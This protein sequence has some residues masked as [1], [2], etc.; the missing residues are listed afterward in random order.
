MLD[1]R[2][3]LG[4]GP[5]WHPDRAALSWVEIYEGRVNWLGLDGSAGESVEVGRRVG[6]AVPAAGGALALATDEG[7]AH[8]GPDGEYVFLAAVDEDCDDWFMNDGRCD[9][10]GRFWAGTVGV[11]ERGLAAERAG[12]LYCLETDGQVRRV[13]DG[14]S[15]SNGL[16]W[17]PDG[18]TFYY[19]DSLAG[20]IDAF[21]FDLSS[22][23]LSGRRRVVELGFPA[24]VGFVDGICVDAD[25]GLWAA[26]WG[27]GEVRRYTPDGELD[28][29]IRLPVSQPTSCVFAGDALDV[30]VITSA[31]RG[32]SGDELERQPH[33]GSVFRCRP[34]P[35]GLPP[36]PCRSVTS[37]EI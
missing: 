35:T 36:N 2:A 13:L 37:L 24:E 30:L 5:I 21:E 16:D 15:L 14:V 25:G 7:F 8:I 32:L 3:D 4:E 31:R 11:N 22:G 23:A 28:A 34:G 6:A 17:S 9:A 12:S 27:L 26:I 33:A 29:S 1:A 10:L 19:V 20:G 18:R